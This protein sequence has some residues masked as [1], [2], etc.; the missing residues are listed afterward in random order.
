MVFAWMPVERM[1]KTDTPSSAT[2]YSTSAVSSASRRC[3]SSLDT[4]ASARAAA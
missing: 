2:T 3:T 1:T 4:D